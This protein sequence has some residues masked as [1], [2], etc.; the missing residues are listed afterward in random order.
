METLIIYT[1]TVYFI[2][3][4]LSRS[5]ITKRARTWLFK[6]LH[7]KLTYA[8]NCPFCF[9]WWSGVGVTLYLLLHSGTLYLLPI[10]LFCAPVLC[11]T[12]DLLLRA[13]LRINEP[14]VVVQQLTAPTVSNGSFTS[15][16]VSSGDSDK[17]QSIIRS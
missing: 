2:F 7:G 15:Y 16:T 12:L 4:V 5:E 9:A 13:L 1:L 17:P 14:P 8:L 6:R 3:H 10:H 11:Y